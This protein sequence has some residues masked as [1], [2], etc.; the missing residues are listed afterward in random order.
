MILGDAVN[1][2][3]S[4]SNWEQNASGLSAVF[5]YSV[6]NQLAFEVLRFAEGPGAV[7]GVVT[8]RAYG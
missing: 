6:P 4:W 1:G 5:H 2:K 3:V 8:P 7:A